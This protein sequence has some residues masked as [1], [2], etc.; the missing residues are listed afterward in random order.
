MSTRPNVETN[1]D[2]KL[3]LKRIGDSISQETIISTNVHKTRTSPIPRKST[4]GVFSLK[5]SASSASVNLS[6]EYGA[7]MKSDYPLILRFHN[8]TLGRA[9][10]VPESVR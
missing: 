7:Y 9:E 5:Y 3:I 4:A 1:T 2:E 10:V 6:G 8:V